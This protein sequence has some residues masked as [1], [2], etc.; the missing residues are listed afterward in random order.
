MSICSHDC[1]NCIFD[2]CIC[3]DYSDDLMLD[4]QLDLEAKNNSKLTP[5]QKYQRS[6]KGKLAMHRY[7]VSE[8]AKQKM[9]RYNKSD[10]G[11]ERF[12]RFEQT[13]KRKAYRREWQKK[14]YWENKLKKEQE[15]L[16][17]N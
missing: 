10:K 17:Q 13:E 6:E 1:F 9:N 16:C 7:N 8:K 15:L 12:K 14:K 11:K 2:D 4:K 3:D 5:R